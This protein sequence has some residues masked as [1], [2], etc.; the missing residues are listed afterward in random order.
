MALMK[1]STLNDNMLREA[2]AKNP[3][4][5]LDNGLIF[6]GPVRLAFVN[7]FRPAKP[8]EPG[9]E[10]KYGAALL[11]PPGTS[12]AVFSQAWTQAAKEAFPQNWDANGNPVGLHLPFHDQAE[13]AVGAKPYAGYT[14]GAITFAVSSKFKPTIVDGN[15]NPIVDEDR[16]YAGCWAYVA[17]NT[18]KYG[19]PQPKKGISFGLQSVM[20]LA[21][22]QKLAGGGVDPKQAFGHV[23]LTAQSNIAEKFNQLPMSGSNQGA[24]PN[25]LSSGAGNSGNLPVQPLPQDDE[26][27]KLM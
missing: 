7:L 13:K 10:G 26:L 24:A 6:S 15:Q 18:Y 9:K 17:M 27:A 16:V 22:D 19:P 8:N 25:L 2:M 4:R 14:P 12:M 23:V 3:P 1:D 20:F 11:F 5:V 21:D